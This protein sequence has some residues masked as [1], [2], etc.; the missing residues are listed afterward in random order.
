MLELKCNK[1]PL[2]LDL[3]EHELSKRTGI[4][5]VESGCLNCTNF[6]V[7]WNTTLSFPT[8]AQF[9]KHGDLSIIRNSVR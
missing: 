1:K 2:G 8:G 7:A 4:L 9:D 3:E 6:H 5:Y